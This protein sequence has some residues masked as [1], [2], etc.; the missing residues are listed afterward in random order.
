MRIPTGDPLFFRP[1]FPYQV[2]RAIQHKP[3]LS[4]SCYGL[5]VKQGLHLILS[6]EIAEL[7]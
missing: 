4:V 6:H 3:D 7:V 2:T 5:T 1:E